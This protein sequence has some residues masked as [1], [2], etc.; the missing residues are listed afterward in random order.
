MARE[1]SRPRLRPALVSF[2]REYSLPG[3]PAAASPAVQDA[4]RQTQFL[5][6][7]DLALFERAMNLQLAIVAASAKTRE[8]IAA[9][10]LALWSRTFAYLAGACSLA[11]GGSYA[12][13]PPLL[14][15]ACD[16]IAAQR[17]LLATGAA[18]FLEWLPEAVRQDPTHAAL[19]VERGRFRAGSVLAE[20]ERLGATYR[21]LT[22][23]SMPHFGTTALQVAPDSSLQ[24]LA[25]TFADCT[26]HLGWAELVFGWLL[27][28]AAGQM[29][30][31][32]ASGAFAVE[33]EARREQERLSAEIGAA[34]ANPRR[35]RV[36]EIEGGRYL[37]HNFR[38][39]SSGVPRRLVL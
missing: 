23:L 14:R 37:F 16:C 18:D 8:P 38:R 30:T 12:A 17:S 22:D 19:A 9:A 36:E 24:K 15:T 28:L 33:D 11:G 26:F 32:V 2:P 29:E 21:L 5:L 6:A 35:C 31:A 27:V 39:R 34:L 10:L 4:Y 25:L 13:C 7:Q 20:D 1:P 3:R